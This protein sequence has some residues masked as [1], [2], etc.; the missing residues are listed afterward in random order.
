[1]SASW[2]TPRTPCNPIST[3]QERNKQMK[4]QTILAVALAASATFAQEIA[5]AAPAPAASVPTAVPAASTSA[6]ATTSEEEV[7]PN[8]K[9][10]NDKFEEFRAAKRKKD[11]NW[12]WGKP[13]PVSQDTYF[14]VQYAVELD[15]THPEF[16]KARWFAFEKAYLRAVADDVIDTYGKLVGG[17]IS[18]EFGDDST[19]HWRRRGCPNRSIRVRILSPSA[20]WRM[21]C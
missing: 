3:T 1:M 16:I 7:D 4:I 18:S 9:S 21:M 17:T 2:P 13:D 15:S 6:V 14:T 12:D 8:E 5:P 19:R 10:L 20:N 11:P